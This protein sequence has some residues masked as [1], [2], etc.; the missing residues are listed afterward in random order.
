MKR[1]FD[2]ITFDFDGVLLHNDYTDSFFQ[3][4]RDVGLT[5]PRERESYL[6]RFIHDYFGNGQ[7]RKDT[8]EY[9][10]ANFWLVANRRFL[11]ALSATGNLEKA[12]IALTERLE[13]MD[14]FYFYETG[15]HEVLE[16]VKKQ[17]YR[18]AMLTN[19]D[20]HIH[21]FAAEWDLIEPFEFIATRDTVGKPKPHPDVY[22]HLNKMFA[23]PPHRA[24][25]IGDN[26]YADISG[27]NAAG[28]H[29]ILIDPDNL[30]PDW[31]VPRILTLH[32]LLEWLASVKNN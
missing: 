3:T 7:S 9:G 24:L 26:P 30:F 10:R 14:V 4:C 31:D 6:M 32:D 27:A 28:W 11:D 1:P 5:W 8:E 2:L 29:S 22:Y 20:D 12:V 13:R 17:G 15:V 25:H 21:E 16:A 18:I 19:R 23:I